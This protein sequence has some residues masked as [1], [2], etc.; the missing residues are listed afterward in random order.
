MQ[1]SLITS[2][3]VVS[4]GGKSGDRRGAERSMG[5]VMQC[6]TYTHMCEARPR[7]L[8]AIL[9]S[10]LTAH[11]ES[12]KSFASAPSVQLGPRLMQRVKRGRGMRKREAV[13]TKVGGVNE[14]KPGESQAA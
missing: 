6:C 2:G 13:R 10:L 1:Q 12:K 9:Y 7:S 14:S 3:A 5:L 11:S 4:E 8:S